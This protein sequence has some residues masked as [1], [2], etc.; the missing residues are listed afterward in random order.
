VRNRRQQQEIHFLTDHLT[1]TAVCSTLPPLYINLQHL[2]SS[3][4][5]LRLI[6][7]ICPL[8]HCSATPFNPAIDTPPRRKYNK[9]PNTFSCIEYRASSIP[10]RDTR[11]TMAPSSVPPNPTAH[12][13]A[14]L[15]PKLNDEDPD[16]RFMALS[17]LHDILVVAHSGFL[18]HDEVTCAKT[19]EGLL[20]TL[21][22]T[23]GEVQNQAVKCLGPFVNKIPDKILCPMIEK[24]SNLQTDNTVDQSIPS[25]AL[26]EVVVSLPHP[27]PGV[28]RGKPVLDA[29]SAI[30][31]VLIPRLVGYHVIQPAQQGLPKVPKGMLQVDLEKGTDSNAIDVLTEVARCFGPMLQDAEINALQKITFEILENDRASSMMKKKSVTAISTLAGY[32]SDQL[33]SG[34]LSRVIELLR[35][36]HLTRT[37]RKLYITILGSM[38][39]YVLSH[40]MR[41]VIH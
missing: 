40:P 38:A 11:A 24:L 6:V 41:Q 2:A 20:H 14:Q 39:R 23:N 12:N 18:Q 36:A 25:L 4:L 9:H 21:V 33:L 8:L 1:F 22:D 26:R 16:F 32:F 13:V 37:K 31:K 17:D 15:L 34:F 7:L 3:S 30:S 28:A 5:L 27:V 10:N 29:Y 19:V 35:D